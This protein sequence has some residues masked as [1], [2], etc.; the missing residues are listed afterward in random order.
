MNSIHRQSATHWIITHNIDDMNIY[1]SAEM[2]Q[3]KNKNIIC[4]I[5]SASISSFILKFL[6]ALCM[7]YVLYALKEKSQGRTLPNVVECVCL[8][9]LTACVAD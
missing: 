3:N 1:L 8:G 2:R 5:S 6:T 4:A 9:T 7:I